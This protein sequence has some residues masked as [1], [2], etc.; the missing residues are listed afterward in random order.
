MEKETKQKIALALYELA[1][2]KHKEGAGAELKAI[3]AFASELLPLFTEHQDSS[4]FT[5]AVRA[6][7]SRG[8]N[9]KAIK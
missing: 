6:V 2:S 1:V 4:D 9:A 7:R 5:A 8:K 3:A